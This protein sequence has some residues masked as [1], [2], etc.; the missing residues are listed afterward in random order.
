M[1]ERLAPGMG[2]AGHVAHWTRPLWGTQGWLQQGLEGR[3][4]SHGQLCELGPSSTHMPT[5]RLLWP[6]H[7]KG[8]GPH[9]QLYTPVH[10]SAKAWPMEKLS[11]ALVLSLTKWTPF[12]NYHYNSL[13]CSHPNSTL[14]SLATYN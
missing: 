11:R 6:G 12:Y 10:S 8:P 3:S 13:L 1:R 2:N 7:P 14:R 4:L 5:S 9:M